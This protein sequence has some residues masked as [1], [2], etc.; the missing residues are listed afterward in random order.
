MSRLIFSAAQWAE[1]RSTL[2][3]GDGRERM[4]F[5]LCGWSP[6]QLLCHRV[7][8]VTERYYQRSTPDSLSVDPI[9]VNSILNE[10]EAE[11]FAVV[12][13]HSH[14]FGD[15]GAQFSEADMLGE[16]RLFPLVCRRMPDRV[17]GAIVLTE[18]DASFRTWTADSND[19]ITGEVLVWQQPL[20]RY[21]TPRNPVP[22]SFVRE[23]IFLG[24]DSSSQIAQLTLAIVGLGGTGS[25]VAQMVTYLGAKRLIL[26]DPDI[27][28]ESNLSRLVGA[29]FEDIGSPKVRV[30]ETFIRSLRPDI[31]V[32]CVADSVLRRRALESLISSDL[33]FSCT[34]TH[35]SRRLLNQVAWQYL[36]PVID[37][38]ALIRL[39]PLG[40]TVFAGGA[41]RVLMAGGFC[42]VCHQQIDA[43]R[44]A[45]ELKSDSQRE[46][47]E[48]FGYVPGYAVTEPA[49]I[50][51]NA[52]LTG[53][54]VSSFL[55]FVGRFLPMDEGQ[56][57]FDL[58]APAASRTSSQAVKT[59]ESCSPSGVVGRGD[60]VSLPAI[61]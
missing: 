50:G 37:M 29:S 49:V 61:P 16:R 11:G 42:M 47:D 39:D 44:V 3:D 22:S 52:V 10:A 40:E 51:V 33:I 5:I 58:V 20:L 43:A 53:I 41:V 54:A 27:V 8:A 28:E 59:C 55:S 17:H 34:D 7:V 45:Y 12:M 46:L 14:P 25:L 2:T 18:N 32:I 21:P 38:G 1:L 13:A 36:K 35:S 6:Q 57:F 9:Y 24:T 26:I 23:S 30:V 19:P 4:A 48:Q 15:I 56:F 60:S 31:D